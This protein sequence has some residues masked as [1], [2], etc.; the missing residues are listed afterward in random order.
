MGRA[1]DWIRDLSEGLA[2][3]TRGTARTVQV[4]AQR[5]AAVVT[6]LTQ[7]AELMEHRAVLDQNQQQRQ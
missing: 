1:T 7:V 5:R 4:L 2:G 3:R 6:R